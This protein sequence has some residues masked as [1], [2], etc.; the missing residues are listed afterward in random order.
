MLLSFCFFSK[1]NHRKPEINFYE[2]IKLPAVTFSIFFF[3]KWDN[4]LCR[5]TA[6]R[7]GIPD[8]LQNIVNMFS[9][10]R[11]LQRP[12]TCKVL[13]QLYNIRRAALTS[14]A[15]AQE[16]IVDMSPQTSSQTSKETASPSY[17]KPLSKLDKFIPKE[18]SS[19]IV[20][21]H[22]VPSTATKED[23]L[24]LARLAF[25]DVDIPIQESEF[26]N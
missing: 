10:R 24:R 14:H 9:I 18:P 21:I 7:P 3:S 19:K 4:R 26:K 11:I 1:Q 25:H 2:E 20:S 23:V 5:Q 13:P 17:Y 22:N 12:N 16:P 8:Q 6:G 15:A